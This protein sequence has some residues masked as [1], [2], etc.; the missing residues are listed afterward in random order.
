VGLGFG[1]GFVLERAGF[2]SA[3]KLT[4]QFY[5]NDMTVLKVMFTAIITAM[6][7]VAL[8]TTFGLLDFE[9]VW[10]NP[11]YLGSG[12]VGGLIFGVGFVIGGYC[13]G[14]A[15]VSV[16]TLKLDGLLFV[17][18]VLGGILGFG[19]TEPLVD[20][21][22]NDSGNYGRLT[23]FDWLGLP[24]PVVVALAVALAL[25][26]FAGGEWVERWITG[27]AA[28][29]PRASRV[30][31]MVIYGGGLLGAALLL[32]AAWRPTAELRSRALEAAIER[33]LS[34]R[35]THVEAAELAQ[36]LR[37][38]RVAL[39]VFDLRSEPEF[40]RFHLL[41]A[42]RVPASD[43][44]AVRARPNARVKVLVAATEA[45]AEAA[46]RTLALQRVDNLYVLAGGL[47]AWLKLFPAADSPPALALGKGHVA[48]RPPKLAHGAPMPAYVARIRAPGVGTQ[49][50][51]GCGG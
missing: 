10:V 36:L 6:V 40:N 29:S 21:F 33:T 30:R 16:A 25:A 12:I 48:S 32:S 2:G 35:T 14:T 9:K 5:L 18:G 13:P 45:D 15:L 3:R 8:A 50:S 44:S 26:F 17:L 20:A 11:T 1:F 42:T 34:Q 38:K 51:G 27:G 22:W 37:D 46:Y 49:K 39:D 4:N 24:M 7:C 28:A 23:L 47:P 19:Y 31:P 43:L 41:D